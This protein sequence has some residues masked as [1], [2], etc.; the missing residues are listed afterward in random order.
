MDNGTPWWHES[1]FPAEMGSVSAARNF[2]RLHLTEHDLRWL[3]DDARV[4]VNE[5]ATN[6]V[7]HAPTPFAVALCA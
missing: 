2:V 4:V 5:F 7:L 1:A 3:V 6:A